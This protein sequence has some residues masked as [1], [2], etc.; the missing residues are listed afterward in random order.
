MGVMFS[1][2]FTSHSSSPFIYFL[3]SARAI[4]PA[5]AAR[6][7]TAAAAAAH[8]AQQLRDDVLDVFHIDLGDGEGGMQ[9]AG[10][11]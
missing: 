2:P 1:I 6:C 7:R 11:M 4:A 8:L 9:G 5:A 10:A 3:L